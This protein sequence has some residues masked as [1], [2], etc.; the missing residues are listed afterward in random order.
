ME[1]KQLTTKLKN[2]AIQP[3]AIRLLVLKYLTQQTNAVSLKNIEDALD[4]AD[5]STIFRTL[6]TF[7]K[8]KLIHSIVDGSGIT[9]Y[10]LQLEENTI[11]AKDSHYHFHCKKCQETFCLSNT[12]IPTIDLPKNFMMQEANIIVKGLCANCNQ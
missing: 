3:T 12:N 2:N 5:K 10:A 1:N 7:E 11:E 9:K 6:K 4:T 8:N